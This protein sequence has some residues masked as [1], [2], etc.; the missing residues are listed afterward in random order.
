MIGLRTQE[1]NKF[2]K[3]FDVVQDFAAKINCIFFLD[4]G[5]G[6]DYTNDDM[7]FQDLSGW[8]IPKSDVSE[9]EKDYLEFNDLDKWDKYYKFAV[10]NTEN[11][12]IFID[13]KEY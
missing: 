12:N 13:F 9:F 7:I 10:W 6:H 8:L 2:I 1:K 5:E 4:T 11:K 3:F